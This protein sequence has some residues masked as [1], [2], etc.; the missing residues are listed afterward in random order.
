MCRA[1]ITSNSPR[2]DAGHHR[3]ELWPR[4]ATQRGHVVV[5]E[6][7]GHGPASRLDQSSHVVAL[8]V[9]AEP[10]A[11]AVLGLA[12]VD[13]GSHGVHHA[14][15]C[16]SVVHATRNVRSTPRM[17]SRPRS[18]AVRSGSHRRR[19]RSK[20]A[21]Q[22]RTADFSI[23]AD[24]MRAPPLFGDGSR[25]C[26]AIPDDGSSTRLPRRRRRPPAPCAS[27]RAGPPGPAAVRTVCRGIAAWPSA[28]RCSLSDPQAHTGT[29]LRPA[30]TGIAPGSARRRHGARAESRPLPTEFAVLPVALTP[31]SAHSSRNSTPRCARLTAPGRASP[32]PPPT[33]AATL[34]VWCGRHKRRALDQRRAARQQACH[35]VDRRHLQRFGFRQRRQ[36][37][38]KAL[39]QHRF[40]DTGRAG[41]HQVMGT[42]RGDLDC[43]PGL[44]LAHHVGEVRNA[45]SGAGDGASIRSSS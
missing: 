34:D 9:D 11:V 26:H 1:T 12:E 43:E 16:Y 14:D 20:L 6:L 38:R 18:R 39:R 40:A 21:P 24:S 41:H 44:R 5:D 15:I 28:R 32:V 42:G 29:G 36:Q 45:G 31:I 22:Q 23:G 17:L 19:F 10:V 35:R 25:G 37:P 7:A 27:R 33:S 13:S 8:A 2:V 30:P 4:L 3:D